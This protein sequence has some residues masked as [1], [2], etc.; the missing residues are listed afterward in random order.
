MFSVVSANISSP[1][2][3]DGK[4]FEFRIRIIYGQLN[5]LYKL[6][7][8]Y[9][10][11]CAGPLHHQVIRS[12]DIDKDKEVLVLHRKANQLPVPSLCWEM[13]REILNMI[14]VIKSLDST[15]DPALFFRWQEQARVLSLQYTNLTGDVLI[16]SGTVAYLGAFT[17][18]FR[19]VSLHDGEPFPHNG[20][21]CK[22]WVNSMI[23][24]ALATQG[25]M[26]LTM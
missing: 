3:H 7:Q 18:A 12:H 6:G 4:E 16:S 11:W 15:D 2:C 10:C 23:P 26:L 20:I 21:F 17:S 9:E 24:D 19:Q 25:A 22:H 1:R 5:I 14:Q 13:F 8:H